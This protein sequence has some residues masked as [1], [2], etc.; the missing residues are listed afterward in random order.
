MIILVQ[1]HEIKCTKR[2]K[3]LLDIV[4]LFLKIN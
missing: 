2:W 4:L 3:I 1:I